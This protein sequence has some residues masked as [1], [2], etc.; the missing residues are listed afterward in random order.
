MQAPF[1][2]TESLRDINTLEY[3]REYLFLEFSGYPHVVA[4]S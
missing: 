3:R 1:R 4:Q 2:L